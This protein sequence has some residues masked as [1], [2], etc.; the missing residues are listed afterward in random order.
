MQKTFLGIDIGT[1]GIR[2]SVI[3]EQAVE[4]ASHRLTMP[5][6]LHDGASSQ[7]DSQIW[8]N[9]LEDCL[10]ETS[11]LTD[12]NRLAAIAVDGT[13]S[14][15][16]LCLDDGTPLTPAVMYN[17]VSSVTQAAKITDVADEES[18]A[19]GASSSLAKLMALV[20]ANPAIAAQHICHQTDYI[21]GWL[22][23]R[24][25]QSDENNC[26]KLGYDVIERCWPTWLQ[27]LDIPHHLLPDVTIP[28]TPIGAINAERA[29]QFGVNPSCMI[30]SGTTDSIAAF[31]ATGADQIGDAVTSLGSSLV[32]KLLSDRPVY[33]KQYGVYS[34]RY[35]HDLWLVGGASNTGCKVLSE[36]FSQTQIDS[37]TAQL[38]PD[39]ET[40]LDYYPLPMNS[41]GERFPVADD[42]KTPVLEPR[43]ESDVE[44]F[45]ALLE[46][47]AAIEQQAYGLLEQ[48]GGQYPSRVLTAGGGSHNQPWNQIRERRLGVPVT[49]ATHTEA[50]YGS[51]LL[52]RK[53]QL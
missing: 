10:H 4:I 29:Q 46:S 31:I 18:A 5:S 37:M 2:T 25:G 51:A 39:A 47:I 43:P 40:G 33:A 48:L 3:D 50:S 30:V 6:P 53:A 22:S 19:H 21:S 17:D 1:S 27:Q 12:F 34:H 49:T 23:G 8:L 45:Q 52:A 32:I 42:A 20:E 14:T 16:L 38:N 15:I 41:I 35:Q 28:A 44:Y 36:L 26:L 13:S 24:Y 7:Q 11:K 9:C